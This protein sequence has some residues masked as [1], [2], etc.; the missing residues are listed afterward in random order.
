MK[1]QMHEREV[2]LLRDYLARSESYFEFGVG[3]STC[4]AATLVRKRICGID[5]DPRWI[6]QVTAAV[7][8][9]PK[10]NLRH[11][12]I[13][14][15]GGWGTPLSRQAEEKFPAYSRSVLTFGDTDFDFCLV[16]GRFRVACF[17]E[18]LNALPGD[19]VIAMHDYASRPHYH[20][21]ENYARPI[22]SCQQLTMFVRRRDYDADRAR[23]DIAQHRLEWA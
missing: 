23:Q 5:S 6:K 17:L 9:D 7:R 4:L 12:D 1:I 3:G 10:V 19:A 20:L 16:D 18:A 2:D 22:A 11:V 21:V 13:G 8:S 14:P 15:T